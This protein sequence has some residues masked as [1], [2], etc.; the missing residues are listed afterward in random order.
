MEVEFD[1]EYPTTT[2]SFLFT[3]IE[4]NHLCSPET[5]PVLPLWITFPKVPAAASNCQY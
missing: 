5:A 1:I 4:E 3:A 2:S